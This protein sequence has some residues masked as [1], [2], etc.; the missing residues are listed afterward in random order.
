M[1]RTSPYESSPALGGRND[2]VAQRLEGLADALRELTN[3]VG[4]VLQPS[5]QAQEPARFNRDDVMAE[6]MLP[7]VMPN[8]A[9]CEKEIERLA[10]YVSGLESA[11][12]RM[13]P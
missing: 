1:N 2:S 11:I 4:Y 8:L 3:R 13:Y 6:R 12:G 5:V 9:R 10:D 7:A